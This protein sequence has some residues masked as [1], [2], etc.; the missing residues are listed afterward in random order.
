[1][2]TMLT[3]YMM[4]MD[5]N[6]AAATNSTTLALVSVLGGI[7]LVI[8]IY[9]L[10][11]QTVNALDMYNIKRGHSLEVGAGSSVSGYNTK[12]AY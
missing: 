1:M 9:M 4:S 5:G 12:K 8:F 11:R 3:A 7:L 2:S 10:I 6:V